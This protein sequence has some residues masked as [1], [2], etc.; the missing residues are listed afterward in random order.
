M[1]F[2]MLHEVTAVAPIIAMVGAWQYYDVVPVEYVFGP[3]AAFAQAGA[4]KFIRWFKKRGWFGLGNE[5]AREGEERFEKEL[6]REAKKGMD[7]E[8]KEQGIGKRVMGFWGRSRGKNE[9]HD[10]GG[11]QKVVEKTKSKTRKAVDLVRE[12]AT[13]DNTEF[14]YKVGVQIVAAYA[15]T[16][17]LFIPRIALSL[18]LTP[19]VARVMVWARMAVFRR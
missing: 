10:E 11:E 3:W 15:I 14:G 4:M 18:W 19:P 5:G 17:V 8:A 6:D 12:K 7:K 16:K 13:L 1:A 9:D 2:L